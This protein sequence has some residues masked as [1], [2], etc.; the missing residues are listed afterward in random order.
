MKKILLF[1]MP[2]P[3]IGMSQGNVVSTFRVFPKPDK[4]LEFEKAF[5]L[6]RERHNSPPL[7]D[8]REGQKSCRK[9]FTNLWEKGLMLPMAQERG[10][11]TWQIMPPL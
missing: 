1:F 7:P 6:L 11:G 8:S 3:A 9:I 4:T 2:I 10:P 5:A